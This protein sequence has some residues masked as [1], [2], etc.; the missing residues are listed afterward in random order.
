MSPTQRAPNH[1]L[2]A[3]PTEFDALQPHLKRTATPSLS[4]P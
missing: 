1:L 4:A 2:Q 3:P